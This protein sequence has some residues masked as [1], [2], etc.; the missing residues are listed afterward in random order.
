MRERAFASRSSNHPASAVQTQ[1][2]FVSPMREGSSLKFSLPPNPLPEKALDLLNLAL[3]PMQHPAGTAREGVPLNTA[4]EAFAMAH[5]GKPQA[6][7]R[8]SS[9]TLVD[10][11]DRMRP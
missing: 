4:L 5:H 3:L 11:V 8:C 7:I 6:N 9:S 2:S 10:F 1:R